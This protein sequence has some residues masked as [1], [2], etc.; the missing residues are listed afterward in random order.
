[1][2][3]YS[4]LWVQLGQELRGEVATDA[5]GKSIAIS[6]DGKT[7]T[8]GAHQNDGNGY[9]S[10]QVRVFQF[11]AGEQV[12][13]QRGADIDGAG[14]NNLFGGSVAMSSDGLTVAAGAMGNSDSG[15][16]AGHVRVFVW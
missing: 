10:G 7:L 13:E 6:S 4:S 5:F 2:S 15:N 8:V 9:E 14:A 1:M 11:N 12:W 16:Y 3:L